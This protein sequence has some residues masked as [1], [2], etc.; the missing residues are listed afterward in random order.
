MLH[1]S[2]CRVEWTRPMELY[3]L[4]TFA[5]VA[6]L[7]HLTR[8][9]ERLHVSQPAVSAQI[10]ALEDELGTPLFERGP[11]GMTL[12]T[13]GLEAPAARGPR[14]GRRDGPQEPGARAEGRDRRPPAGGHPLRPRDAAPR[15]PARAR[16]RAPPAAATR[17]AQR[18][19]RRR[20]REG[21]RRRARRELLL[22]TAAPRGGRVD[23]RCGRSSTASSCRR[24]GATASTATTGRR[25]PRC[26]G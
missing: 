13:A 5:A 26:R 24:P 11:S 25:S 9:A 22:R 18:G 12:T 6:E 3:Q 7:G 14:P 20:V 10:R 2:I 17:P 16:G 4:R 23:A 1:S 8:A 19:D 21:A 15:R